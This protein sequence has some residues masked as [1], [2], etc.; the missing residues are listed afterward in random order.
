MVKSMVEEKSDLNGKIVVDLA[1]QFAGR[2]K[3]I[4]APCQYVSPINGVKVECPVLEMETGESFVLS[5]AEHFANLVVIEDDWAVQYYEDVW[6]M[7]REVTKAVCGVAAKMGLTPQV[8]FLMVGKALQ[9]QGGMLL[10]RQE[11]EAH[12]G[13][14]S[15]AAPG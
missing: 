3:T 13:G 5:S 9:A 8:A 11:E 2:V 14:I 4:H 10:K 12:G 7:V 1:R 15:E 6:T